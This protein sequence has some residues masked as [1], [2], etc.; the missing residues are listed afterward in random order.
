MIIMGQASSADR[1]SKRPFVVSLEG[2]IGAGKTTMLNHLGRKL[3]E[4]GYSVVCVPEP[5]EEWSSML[6]E[7]YTDPARFGPALQTFILTARGSALARAF[8][9]RKLVPDVVIIDRSIH[10]GDTVFA[11]LTDMSKD[12]RAL[13]ENIKVQ[14]MKMLPAAPHLYLFI[15]CPPDEAMRRINMRDNNNYKIDI[16][17]LAKL[18]NKHIEAFAKGI[19]GAEM[20]TVPTSVPA[21]ALKSPLASDAFDGDITNSASKPAP[22]YL[23]SEEM[24]HR[25]AVI[26]VD[27]MLEHSLRSCTA[28]PQSS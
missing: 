23:C 9:F 5:V 15:D 16:S 10:V 26:I 27:H 1:D 3:Q 19:A 12:Q 7:F 28:P 17:Y 21:D 11:S 18:Y 6:Q 20:H 4:S 13:Y 2:L 24:A 14:M 22:H 25:A 8:D